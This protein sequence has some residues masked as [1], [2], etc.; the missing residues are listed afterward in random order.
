MNLGAQ[1]A[2][3]HY[4]R[5]FHVLFGN[6]P[7]VSCPGCVIMMRRRNPRHYQ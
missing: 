7:G 6:K 2:F 3:Y 5:F 4:S 1:F